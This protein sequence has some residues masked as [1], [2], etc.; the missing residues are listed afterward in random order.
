MCFGIRYRPSSRRRSRHCLWQQHQ[1][2]RGWQLAMQ[3]C[4]LRYA[5]TSP[6]RHMPCCDHW[7]WMLDEVSA[8]GCCSALHGKVWCVDAIGLGLFLQ[9][10][11]HSLVARQSN[12]PLGEVMTAI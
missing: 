6:M 8:V 1:Q 12:G 11:F 3:A 9:T 2:F 4:L 10:C 5:G 7:Y